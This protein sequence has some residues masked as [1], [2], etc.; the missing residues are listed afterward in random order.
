MV[1][2]YIRIKASGT[3]RRRTH[4]LSPKIAP[5]AIPSPH[6][7]SVISPT[8]RIRAVAGIPAG[9]LFTFTTWFRTGAPRCLVDECSTTRARRIST[10]GSPP[11]RWGPLLAGAA[12]AD[13]GLGRLGGGHVAGDHRD[14]SSFKFRSMEVGYV[15]PVGVGRR[16]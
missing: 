3:Y 11:H 10:D 7:H 13:F 4:I 5:P 6:W 12:A 2:T 14:V 1:I 16:D 8:T 15:V 9:M